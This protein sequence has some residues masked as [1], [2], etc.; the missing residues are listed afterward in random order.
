[1]SNETTVIRLPVSASHNFESQLL[2][3]SEALDPETITDA[4]VLHDAWCAVYH[5]HACNCNLA[6]EISFGTSFDLDE[7][8]L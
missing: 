1:M 8:Q 4:W 6:I 5:G 2:A 3:L 7:E